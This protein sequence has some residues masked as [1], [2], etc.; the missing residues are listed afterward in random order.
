MFSPIKLFH[1]Q[2]SIAKTADIDDNCTYC[3]Y[4]LFCCLN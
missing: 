2:E 4:I 1:D 3:P